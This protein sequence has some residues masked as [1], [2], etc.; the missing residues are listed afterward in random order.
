[1]ND[2][3]PA[4]EAIRRAGPR[5]WALFAA[6]VLM[7]GSAFTV[8]RGGLEAG[9]D[10]M[11]LVVTRLWVGA[12]VVA[13]IA[14]TMGQGL[15]RLSNPKAWAW[16]AVIGLF[17]MA[18][19]F[20][21][22]T[23]AQVSTPSGLAAIYVAATPLI[24]VPLA[25]FFAP[26]DF[27]TPSKIVGVVVGFVGVV[28]LIGPSALSQATATPLLPQLALL[29]AA[30]GYGVSNVLIA[31]APDTP[32]LRLTAGMALSAAVILS[33]IALALGVALP[34]TP[35]PLA[36]GAILGAGPTGIATALA[37]TLVRR[38]GPSFMSMVG[39]LIPLVAL[40]LG[41]VFYAERP[42]AQALVAL[43]IIM[44]GVW[45]AQRRG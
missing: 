26:G 39:Y 23:Y 15:P 22:I 21:L 1:M 8:T 13:A 5:D 30:T 2:A 34:T 45:A 9:A 32:P 28:V 37:V 20:G 25:H 42:S 27:A 38:V 31:R 4:V 29:G 6:I 33:V 18:A 12:A 24:V 7:W 35:G 41:A 43:L 10:P 16:A 14:L 36:A 40:V 11:G 3:P 17:G 19:P 44:T